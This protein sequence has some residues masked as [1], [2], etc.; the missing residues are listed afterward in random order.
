MVTITTA[1]SDEE[2][3]LGQLRRRFLEIEA[4]GGTI[5]RGLRADKTGRARGHADGR[6]TVAR[7]K[8]GRTAML[9]WACR[10]DD[11]LDDMGIVKLANPASGVTLAS[12]E[13]ARE[14][15]GITPAQFARYRA[16]V[17]AQADDAVIAA[18]AWDRLDTGA[19]I[20]DDASVW[21]AVDYARK[22]DTCSAVQLYRRDDGVVVPEAQV[23][24]LQVRA[25]GRV[26]PA[27]H[28]LIRG[29]RTIRQSLVRDHIRA[30]AD[31]RHVMGVIFDPHLFDPEEL[32][33]EG[34]S[35]IEFPQTPARTCPAAKSFY[36]AVHEG[37][38]EHDGD[39]VLRAHVIQAGAKTVGEEWRFSK[40]A[41]KRPIDALIC[42]VMGLGSAAH[43]PVVGGFEWS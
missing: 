22:S 14:A 31:R 6:L 33:D 39:P 41:S 2:S 35:M 30:I 12:L 27:A 26:Q 16:N 37:T 25:A 3:V 40:A 19:T 13:D 20:P 7:S 15:P 5:E 28:T 1:G 10:P 36:E 11:E 38:I 24:A 34:F 17:W 23:W 9:E 42:M 29:D 43:A 21:V 8:S 4:E 18:E 32:A